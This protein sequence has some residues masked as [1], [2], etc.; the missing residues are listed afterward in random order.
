MTTRW[1]LA[2]DDADPA[3]VR[4]LLDWCVARG[5]D[6]FSLHVMALA[7]APGERADAFEDALEP[8]GRPAAVR[9]IV[10]AT[11]GPCFPGRVRLWALD[12]GAVPLLHRFLPL[13]S[14][15]LGAGEPGEAG[16][17]ENLIVY[18]AGELLFAA[19]TNDRVGV[20]QLRAGEREELVAL[21]IAVHP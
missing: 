17:F 1:H 9:S 12:E 21:G 8:W 2:A 14:L 15:R 18:R 20:L 7:D 11:D 10:D 13:A 6:E 5:A 3:S 19:L 4:R 16:W